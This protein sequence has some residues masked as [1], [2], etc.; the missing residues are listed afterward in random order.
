MAFTVRRDLTTRLR[1][2]LPWELTDDQQRALREITADM[3]AP[4]RMHRL[5]MGDVGTGKTVVA[6]FAMLLA[7]ENEFQAALMAPTELLAEQHA[8]T[9]ERLLAPLRL[10]PELLLGRQ[11]AGEKQAVR[12][13]LADGPGAARG[14]HP[15]AHAGERVVPPAGPRRDRRAAPLR[16]GAAGGADR[17]GRGAGRAAAH[18]HADPALARAHALRRPRRVHAAPSPA[19]PRHHPHRRPHGRATGPGAR[20]RP[21][22]SARSGRQAYVVLP[23]IEESERADLRAATTMAQ[24]LAARWPELRVGLVHGRLKA[25][26]RD[27]VMRRFRAGEIHVLVATTVIEVGIDVPERHD[28]GDRAS[29][30]VR[31]G[32]AAPAARPHRARARTRASASSCPRAS[33]PTGCTPSPRRRTASGSRSWIWRSAGWAT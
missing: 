22:A 19:G 33:R 17:E 16:R 18:R 24:S 30:A 25:E 8:A 20:V 5:L 31:P 14:R 13:R 32:A 3:T 7:V 21:D 9:L 4:E 29:R 28:H 23:V 27:D 10:R 11:T 12:A 15:R 1:E 26:E 6:L 2:A